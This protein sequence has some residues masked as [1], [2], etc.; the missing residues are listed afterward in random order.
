MDEKMS[1]RENLP[2][3]LNETENTYKTRQNIASNA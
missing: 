2:R 3:L 1:A